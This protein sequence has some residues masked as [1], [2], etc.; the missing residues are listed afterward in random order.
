MTKRLSVVLAAIGLMIG[1]CGGSGTGPATP[2]A[3]TPAPAASVAPG[4][5]SAPAASVEA[6]G[7]VN[8][9]VGIAEEPAIEQKFNDQVKEFNDSHP[10][11]KVVR[12]SLDNDQLRTI[13]QTRLSSG[14][15]DLFSYDTGP[16]FGGVLARAGLLADMG[17]AYDQ[18]KWPVFDWAKARC[19]YKG[20]VSCLP[21]QV[22]EVG[23]YYNKTMFDANGFTE[24]KTLDQLKTIMDGLKAKGITPLA[25]GDQPKWPAGHQF[26]MT[27]SN[28]VGREGLDAR[29]YGEKPWNDAE[30]VKA[31]DIYFKQFKDAGYFPKD[32][33]AVTYEDANALF[34][35]GKAAMIPT[36]TWLVSEV[37]EKAKFDVG[38][39]PFPAIDGSSVSP[40]AGLGGG[41]F[42]NAKAKNPTAAFAYLDWLL[43]P[44]Q[45]KKWD[46]GTFNSIPAVPIDAASVSVSPLFGK[47]LGDLAESSGTSGTFGYNID[48]LAPAAFNDVMSD[49]FQNVLAGRE[50][51]QGLADK[52]QSAYQKAMAAGETIQKP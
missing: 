16:G 12:E 14:S 30:T 21:G 42:V 35:A 17:P 2:K 31:I 29:F 27:L 44:A 49:G 6:S 50:T 51:P 23:I 20:T 10:N 4:T 40:P 22:E 18:Y 7:T 26:S 37:T 38:F 46:L 41:M 39:M 33:N 52:L 15:I 48:V 9:L 45:I 24:P 32:P 25:F 3:G 13:I 34:Y 36:G 47:V 11:I 19:T 28:I 43:Q 8:L 1:A 5:S